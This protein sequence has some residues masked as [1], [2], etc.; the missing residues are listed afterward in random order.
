MTTTADTDWC[1]EEDAIELTG[2]PRLFLRFL[3]VKENGESYSPDELAEPGESKDELLAELAVAWF[4]AVPTLD[5]GAKLQALVLDWKDLQAG[6][7]DLHERVGLL[8]CYTALAHEWRECPLNFLTVAAG[9][10]L[11]WYNG[12]D[13]QAQE[14]TT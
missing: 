7:G 1:S 9:M 8:V 11:D 10:L 6:G 12:A 3:A 2:L 4:N 14:Y 13:A 5:F